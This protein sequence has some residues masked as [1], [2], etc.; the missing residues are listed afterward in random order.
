MVLFLDLH[1]MRHFA[2]IGYIHLSAYLRPNMTPEILIYSGVVRIMVG[3][4]FTG[5]AFVMINIKYS[6]PRTFLMLASILL[7]WGRTMIL[8]SCSESFPVSCLIWMW[9]WSAEFLNRLSFLVL[10]LQLTRAGLFAIG[11]A[12]NFESSDH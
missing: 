12:P 8:N 11:M 6:R 5:L 7:R 10:L 1:G 3:S 2:I 4:S 9:T